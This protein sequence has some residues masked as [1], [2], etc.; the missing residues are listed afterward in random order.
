MWSLTDEVCKSN[1][2]SLQSCPDCEG[3][4]VTSRGHVVCASCGLVISREYVAPT[5]QMGDQKR[6]NTPDEVCMYP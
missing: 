4:L 3:I 6:S 2:I 5:Y 1:S